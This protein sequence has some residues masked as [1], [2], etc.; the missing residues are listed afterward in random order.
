MR[1]SRKARLWH[2]ISSSWVIPLFSTANV[3]WQKIILNVSI[4][5]NI[6]YFKWL[7]SYPHRSTTIQGKFIF[8][9]INLFSL[10]SSHPHWRRGRLCTIIPSLLNTLHKSS[11]HV[12]EM[13]YIFFLNGIKKS[14]NNPYHHYW[15]ELLRRPLGSG[16]GRASEAAIKRLSPGLWKSLLPC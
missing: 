7:Q 6:N 16:C 4:L 3:T 12:G 5:Y 1:S 11:T 13:T 10:S 8:S 15:Q 14:I 9:V 2:A